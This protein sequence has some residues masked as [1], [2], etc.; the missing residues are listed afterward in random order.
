MGHLSTLWSLGS[1]FAW[2]FLDD[3]ALDIWICLLDSFHY[4]C[5]F[6]IGMAYISNYY[7]TTYSVS[8]LRSLLK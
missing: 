6:V 4:P 7:Y 3:E 2:I 5:P 1:I 8:V